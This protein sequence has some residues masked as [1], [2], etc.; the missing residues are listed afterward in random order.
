MQVKF[1]CFPIGSCFP[2]FCC[3]NTHVI[4]F[5]I[6]Q[7]LIFTNPHA[8]HFRRYRVG[9]DGGWRVVLHVP[10]G[11]LEPGVPH[12]RGSLQT[13]QPGVRREALHH[14]RTGHIREP[15]PRGEVRGV[16]PNNK[17]LQQL[18]AGNRPVPLANS[19]AISV[20]T[21]MQNKKKKVCWICWA[22]QINMHRAQ[23][24]VADSVACSGVAQHIC[25]SVC[26][27][28]LAFMREPRGAEEWK[29]AGAY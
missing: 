2:V 16:A 20:N 1:L 9:C 10:V 15:G 26:T 27:G 12:D 24:N 21:W 5:H 13:Q 22:I 18:P 7:Y 29:R 14:R 19:T 8:S 6:Y 25:K 11:Q 23:W 3:E 28:L 4:S 17:Q